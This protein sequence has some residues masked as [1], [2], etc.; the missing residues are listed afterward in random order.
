MSDLVLGPDEIESLT[1]KKRCHAQAK[2]LRF[3]GIDYKVRPDGSLAVLRKAV[4]ASFGVGVVSIPRR[5]VQ[6]D[7]SQV[8]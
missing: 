3:L 1:D 8:A 7:F 5:K 6:P 2:V 4:E